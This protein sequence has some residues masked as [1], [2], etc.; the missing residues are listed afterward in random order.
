MKVVVL[1]RPN[2]EHGRSVESFIRD[3][4]YQ[5]GTSAKILD[6][7]DIDT[8]DGVSTASLYDVVQY[9]AVLVLAD[10]G[11]LIK[12]WEGSDLPLMNDISAYVYGA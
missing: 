3:F 9:P 7:I 2:S 4:K 11:S 12:S 5:H 10:N 6:L 8:R 1:Y